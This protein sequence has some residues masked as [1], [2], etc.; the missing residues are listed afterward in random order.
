MTKRLIVLR[1][2]EAE[3][4][5]DERVL[6]RDTSLTEKGQRQA[7]AVHKLVKTLE[8]EVVVTSPILR[9]LQTTASVMGGCSGDSA[10][11]ARVVVA[12][13]ARGRLA[14]RAHLCG[15][16]V[17]PRSA[18]ARRSRRS[19]VFAEYDWS[20][21]LADLIAAGSIAAWEAGFVSADFDSG[22]GSVRRRGERL[23]SW[24]EDRPEQTICLVSHGNYLM[25]VTGDSYMDN[26]E[27]RVYA[28]E[29]G[30]WAR[31]EAFYG[32]E[33]S[34]QENGLE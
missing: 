31:C 11:C 17:D 14:S 18:R 10:V 26:C 20:L 1:H 19:G 16:P 3:H 5:V 25:E 2:G 22:P 7:R 29:A 30:R 27:V 4:N 8:P 32:D 12:P 15:L 9:A 13:D 21:A 28:L 23:S 33:R 34:R 24:L 6:K